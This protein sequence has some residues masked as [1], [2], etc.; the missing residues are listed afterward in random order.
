MRR[1][2]SAASGTARQLRAL[3]DVNMLLALF[4]RGHLYHTPAIAWWKENQT[5][6]WASCPITQ[7]GFVRIISGAGYQRPLM[8]PE[9]MD[10][11]AR[12]MATPEH[13]F[14]P[15][16]VSITDPTIFD[17]SRILGPRQLTD[18]YLLALAVRNGGRLV[19]FDRGIP[20]AAVRGAEPRHLVAL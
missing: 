11:L 7:N 2:A 6:G 1:S 4:D 3:F 14:W 20:L 18:V 19:T 12:Q 5:A 15:D 16:D 8:L 17:H 13:A 10:L 9:A